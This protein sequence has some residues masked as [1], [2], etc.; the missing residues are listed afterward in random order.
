MK[1]WRHLL[2]SSELLNKTQ[3]R[4]LDKRPFAANFF[5]VNIFVR[6]TVKIFQFLRPTAK[7]FRRLSLTVSHIESLY[8]SFF[9]RLKLRWWTQQEKRVLLL[10]GG[11]LY[12]A[13]VFLI[14]RNNTD[15]VGHLEWWFRGDTNF[16]SWNFGNKQDFREDVQI[17]WGKVVGYVSRHF[18]F[19]VSVIQSWPS[20]T[21]NVGFHSWRGN[22]GGKLVRFQIFFAFWVVKVVFR[23]LT[24]VVSHGQKK[25]FILKKTISMLKSL[26]ASIQNFLFF[27]L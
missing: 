3:N 8:R 5:M 20:L 14:F 23:I 17:S 13:S 16:R 12:T 15:G 24:W 2:N 4:G 26:T 10:V 1:N 6:Q 18:G 9:R 27:F 11:H 7:Y 21:F 22:E 19:C 25:L